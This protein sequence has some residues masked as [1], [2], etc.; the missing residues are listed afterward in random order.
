MS[1]LWLLLLPRALPL[2]VSHGRSRGHR[3]RAAPE[4]EADAEAL[5]WE[6][7][8]ADLEVSGWQPDATDLILEAEDA[9]VWVEEKR[10]YAACYEEKDRAPA[11]LRGVYKRSFTVADKEAGVRYLHA[12]D[13][14][15]PALADLGWADLA[16]NA[17]DDA[18]ALNLVRDLLEAAAYLHARGLPHLSL[19]DEYVRVGAARDGPAR[20]KVVGVGAGPKLVATRR[21]FSLP[22]TWAFNAPETMDG[23]LIQ[24]NL[25]ALFRMDAWSVGVCVAMLLAREGA[26]PFRAGADWRAGLFS[27]RDAVRAQIEDVFADFSGFLR[28]TNARSKGL[29]F[30][31]GW[32]VE[33]LLG[34]LTPD[35]N[36]RLTV[37]E[38]AA[39]ARRKKPKKKKTTETSVAY[40]PPGAREIG[41]FGEGAQ[42]RPAGDARAAG[43]PFRSLEAMVNIASNGE[44]RC[45]LEAFGP[46]GAWGSGVP[47]GEVLGFRNRADGD[48][49]DVFLPGLARGGSRTGVAGVDGSKELEVVRILGVVLI[50]GGNHKLAV[51]VRGVEPDEALVSQDVRKFMDAYVASHPTSANRV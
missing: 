11:A 50:K 41:R 25:K 51:E 39:I 34:L 37:L 27:D 35:P 1:L 28:R 16:R 5:A 13:A 19:N 12:F 43:E 2:H 33:V 29:L 31:H 45:R 15:F 14:H 30:R 6:A 22:E 47:Y 17:T 42:P 36:E 21:P 48:R 49:W 23:A 32:L 20:L 46:R 7:A 26:S 40:A 18:A 10:E 3:C 8:A 24:S 38:A 44:C 4:R 9:L